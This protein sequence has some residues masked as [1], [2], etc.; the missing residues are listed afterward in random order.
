MVFN[1]L[2][3]NRDDHAKQISFLMDK[4]GQWSRSPAYDMTYAYNPLGEFTNSHQM[5][6]NRKRADILD[7]DFLAVTDR[8]GMRETFARDA[9][10]R[11]QAAVSRW[12]EYAKQAG[13]ER[14]QQEKIARLILPA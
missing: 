8:Q 11:V 9:I 7:K 14:Q 3:Y 5:T 1:V 13:I 2:A 6:I 12:G 4:T 10:A